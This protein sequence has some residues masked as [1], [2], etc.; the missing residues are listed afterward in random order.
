[1]VRPGTLR[2]IELEHD[3]AD[4]DVVAWLEP[5]LLQGAD[6]AHAVQAPLDVREG[7]QV[8]HVVAG[9][10]AV[11]RLALDAP[12][13]LLDLLDLDRLA[14]TSVWMAAHLDRPSPSRT[15][16]ALSHKEY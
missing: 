7:V 8:L 9:D 10:Q 1:M 4:L 3:A 5:M 12:Q 11:D 2:G 15:V 13:A 6:H 14:A 16:R